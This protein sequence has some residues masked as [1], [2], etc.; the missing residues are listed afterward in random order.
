MRIAVLQRPCPYCSSTEVRLSRRPGFLGFLA[1]PFFIAPF[2][3][4]LC[5]HRFYGFRFG[6]TGQI[7]SLDDESWPPPFLL[8][9][10]EE[11]PASSATSTPPTSPTSPA[12]PAP[13]AP[14]PGQTVAVSRTSKR[15]QMQTRV[16]IRR[17]ATR[18]EEIVEP[19]NVSRGGIAFE[20]RNPYELGDLIHLTMHYREGEES[21]E[22]P[23]RIVQSFRAVGKCT[24]GVQFESNQP[25]G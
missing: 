9:L 19:L 13:P 7:Q 14:P 8:G 25:G 12:P 5:F 15:V 10:N 4:L 21:L 2:R 6:T 18:A 24:Y 20:S 1:R 17:D 3:C 23:A 22:T 11:S 16:R